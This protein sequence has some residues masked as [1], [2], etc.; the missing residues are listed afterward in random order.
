[1]FVQCLSLSLFYVLA[2]CTPLFGLGTCTKPPPR[3]TRP[4]SLSELRVGADRWRDN[5]AVRAAVQVLRIGCSQISAEHSS[6][7]RRA[8]SHRAA[9]GDQC[10]AG[11]ALI[12]TLTLSRLRLETTLRKKMSLWSFNLAP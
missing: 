10:S 3:L 6:P 11:T 1:M 4:T 5:L 9:T 8:S 7:P 12:G 2:G